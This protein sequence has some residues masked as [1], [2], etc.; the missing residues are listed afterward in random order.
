MKKLPAKNEC[1]R[2][3][4]AITALRQRA[5]LLCCIRQFFADQKVWEVDPPLL[6]QFGVSDPHLDNFCADFGDRRYLQT[7]PE[8]AMK[9]LLAA[10]SGDIYSLGKAFRPDEQGQHHNA[11]FTLL[12]WYRIGWNHHQLMDEVAA[13]V[14]MILGCNQPE[15]WTYCQLFEDFVGCNPITASDTELDQTMRQHRLEDVLVATGERDDKLA[16][17]MHYV[18]EPQ[19]GQHA[20]CFVYDY[21]ASQAALA[22]LSKDDSKVAERFELYYQGVELA[23][24]YHE[25]TDPEAQASRFRTDNQIRERLEKAQV[26][27]D[28]RLISAL[29]SG[30]PDCAGVAL[31]V[32]RLLMLK[33]GC[34]TIAEVLPFAWDRA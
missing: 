33:L 24:G 28:W 17:L 23:N 7:S 13:L 9:R 4:A 25:L 10:G 20:P 1:W 5:E 32:D 6:A 12:E 31:G 21:P 14:C 22:R 3:S 15:K 8:Y 27:S 26:N 11:E 29:E 2:P 16:M 34:A 30:L 19:I 18:I